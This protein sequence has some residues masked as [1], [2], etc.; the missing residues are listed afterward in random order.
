MSQPMTQTYNVLQFI[1]V[2][3]EESSS[4]MCPKMFKHSMANT[5]KMKNSFKFQ[6]STVC[7]IQTLAIVKK[8][9]RKKK[10]KLLP[11]NRVFTSV[12]VYKV[13]HNVKVLK[14]TTSLVIISLDTVI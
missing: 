14:S 12:H 10:K 1:K 4:P 3:S 11:F 8:K 9:T 13:A 5:I 7:K 2:M 6:C